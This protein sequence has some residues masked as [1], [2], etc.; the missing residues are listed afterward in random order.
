VT[1]AITVQEI[2]QA[3]RDVP[4]FPK[5]GIMFKD[6]TPLLLDPGRFR[7]ALELMAAPFGGS[8]VR[9]VV[10]IESR[11]FLLGAPIALLLEAGLVPIRKPGKLPAARGRVE[12]TLEYGTDAL[13]MHRDAVGQG[14]RVLIVD[15]VLATG[16]TAEA[17]AK[18]V[19]AH[20]AQV[21]GF[22]FLIELDFLKGRERLRDERVEALLHYA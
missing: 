6:I 10:S 14:D 19:R 15:D 12:Y 21:V 22:T 11:G 7:R 3:I 2:Y 1:K 16:G 9:R 4:D 18:L 8:K 13:E 5:P 20:G 17:A